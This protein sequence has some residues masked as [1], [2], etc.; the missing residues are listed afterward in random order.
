MTSF[1][2]PSKAERVVWHVILI[3]PIIQWAF[4]VWASICPRD[5]RV[6]AGWTIALLNMQLRSDEL[7]G[8]R[9]QMESQSTNLAGRGKDSHLK[10]E[11]RKSALPYGQHVQIHPAKAVRTKQIWCVPEREVY[12]YSLKVAARTPSTGGWSQQ[13]GM[14]PWSWMTKYWMIHRI[15]RVVISDHSYCVLCIRLHVDKKTSPREIGAR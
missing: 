13:S 1:P 7:L 4:T 5:S 6:C 2:L 12:I 15:C 11:H 9:K 3:A 14:A 8:V 10:T